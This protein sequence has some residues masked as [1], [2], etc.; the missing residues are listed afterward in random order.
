MPNKL[1]AIRPL[2][3]TKIVATLGPASDKKE[4]LH[5]MILAGVDAVR[6]NFSHST[7]DYVISFGETNSGIGQ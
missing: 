3:R 7:H 5:S 2:K 1:R 6:I 4:T